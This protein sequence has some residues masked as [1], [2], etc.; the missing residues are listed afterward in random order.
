MSDRKAQQ[1]GTR[2]PLSIAMLEGRKQCLELGLQD[3][4][5]TPWQKAFLESESWDVAVTLGM[6]RNPEG[7]TYIEVPLDF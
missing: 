7:K 4:A 1:H 2:F 6:L 3:P 5:L